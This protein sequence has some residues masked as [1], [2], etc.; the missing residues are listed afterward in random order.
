MGKRITIGK[1]G[2]VAG[3]TP[4]QIQKVV[5]L[6]NTGSDAQRLMYGKQLIT[7]RPEGMSLEEYQRIRRNETKLIKAALRK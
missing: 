7:A 5:E 2:V 4:R 6:N 3:M 1:I